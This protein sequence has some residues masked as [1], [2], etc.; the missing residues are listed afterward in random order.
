MPAS[1]RRDMN[2]HFDAVHKRLG[3]FETECR[4][5]VAGVRRPKDAQPPSVAE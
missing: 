1:L 5:L 4:M 3:H 2:G